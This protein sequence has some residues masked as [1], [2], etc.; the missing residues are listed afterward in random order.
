MHPRGALDTHK[1]RIYV[2]RFT[3]LVRKSF[4]T[5]PTLPG[6]AAALTYRAQQGL[7][8]WSFIVFRHGCRF[9]F[10]RRTL[11]RGGTFII[12]CSAL[13][14]RPKALLFFNVLHRPHSEK[15]RIQLNSKLQNNVTFQCLGL[16]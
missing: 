13:P 3:D 5:L 10:E 9:G 12:V 16:L 7:P 6:K 1:S 15:L 4:G 14:P 2:L 8:V 11:S